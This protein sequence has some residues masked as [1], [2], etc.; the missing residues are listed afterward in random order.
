MSDFDVVRSRR[1]T[2]SYKWDTTVGEGLLERGAYPLSVADMEF[3]TP[4]AVREAIKDFAESGFFCYTDADGEY[5]DA[6]RGF[7]SRRHGWNIDN[8]WIT[9]T[10]GVVCAINTAVRAFSQPGEGVIIQTPVYYPFRTAIENNGRRLFENPLVTDA[11]GNYVMNLAELE[12]LAS[13]DDVKMLLLCSPHNPVCRVWSA[14]ELRAVGDICLKNGVTVISDE[15]HFDITSKPHTVF[16]LADRRFAQNTVICTAVSKSFNLAG[17]GTSNV[18]IENEALRERFR[19]ALASDGYTCINCV[20]RPATIAAYTLCD[21][22]LDEVNA[23]IDANFELLF[24]YAERL[25]GV[26]ICKREGTYLAWLDMRGLGFGSDEELD[27]FLQQQCLIIPDPGY[28]FGKGGS[29]FTRLN[30]ASPRP[31]LEAAL[32]RLSEKLMKR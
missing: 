6:V 10:G 25:P 27:S 3:R 24:S 12:T 13:R 16:T 1:G 32:E 4:A 7:M 11:D 23:Y 2:G 5:R 8:E 29:G 28:W 26:E 14:S 17:L 21:D 15:I 20:S 18:I 30:L 22:W 9:C 19:K 31:A